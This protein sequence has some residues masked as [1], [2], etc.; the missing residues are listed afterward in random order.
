MDKESS[1]RLVQDR[2]SQGAANTT[3]SL[4]LLK[5]SSELT[6]DL[7]WTAPKAFLETSTFISEATTQ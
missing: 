2:I 3:D 5:S 6:L 4:H 7:T 1:G